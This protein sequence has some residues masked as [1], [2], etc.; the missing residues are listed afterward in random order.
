M[1]PL[2]RVAQHAMADE[3]ADGKEASGR[4]RG[5]PVLGQVSRVWRAV[6]VHSVRQ[7]VVPPV[8][9]VLHGSHGRCARTRSSHC[10]YQKP[11]LIPSPHYV[12][13]AGG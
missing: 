5:V 12:V 1:R 4:A 10:L 7:P 9:G 2:P 11:E 8:Q 3:A 13:M 6:H